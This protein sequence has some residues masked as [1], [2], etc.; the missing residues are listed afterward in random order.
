M[1]E[2]SDLNFD[3]FKNNSN[4]QGLPN[5]PKLPNFSGKKAVLGLIAIFVLVFVYSGFYTIEP[6]EAGVVL[7]F[8]EYQATTEPGLHF[9]LPL[10]IDNVTKVKITR[11]HKVEF[12]FRTVSAGV[13]SK[14]ANSGYSDESLM[15]TGDLNIADVQ[16]IVQYQIKE[17]YKFLFNIRDVER[18][19]R[20]LSEAV[21]RELVGDRSVDEVIV[22]DR[23]Q[24]AEKAKEKLQKN[25][26][27]YEAGVKVNI[28]KLQNVNP[29]KTVQ[30]AFNEVNSA[31]QEQEK[32]VNQAWQNYN[33]VI[34]EAKGKAKQI[35]EQAEGY[36]IN[37]INRAKGDADRFNQIYERYKFVKKVTRTRMYIEA[38]QVALPQVN[39]IYIVDKDQK[40]IL[41]L[42]DLTKGGVK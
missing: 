30:D 42:L 6:D 37:K 20:N 24:I 8:G 35:L 19:I 10:G 9:K 40:S 21:M 29:P 12:G 23:Q 18:T 31:K 34:P 2:F 27:E 13:V 28:V 38:L 17:P 11:V 22:M 41:P 15:L 39:K 7:R 26:D 4:K 3:K 32:I 36:A 1:S 33:K 25:L 16:W 14:F 5:M